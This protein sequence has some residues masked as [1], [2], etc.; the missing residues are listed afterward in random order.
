M[1]SD[2][3]FTIDICEWVHIGSGKEAY[4][5]TNTVNYIRQMLKSKGQF[6][7][8]DYMEETLSHLALQGWY[9]ID[10]AKD[11]NLLFTTDKL[12]NPPRAHL[13]CLQYCQEE[14]FFRPILQ[15]VNHLTV[16]HVCGVW[17]SIKWTS[18]RDSS[19]HFIMSNFGQLIHVQSE[20][21]W[22]HEVWGLVLKYDLK[23]LLDS[24]LIHLQNGP[25]YYHQPF[26]C[27]TSV[28]QLGLDCKIE[29][30]NANQGIMPESHNIWV[31]YSDS[32]LD[33]IFHGRDPSVPVL[34]F[35][36]T[37]LHQILQFQECL[38]AWKI[39]LTC[40]NLCKK[41][42]E[43]I[44]CA[45]AEEYASMIP[46]MYKDPHGWAECI[47]RFIRVLKQPHDMGTVHVRAS[48]GLVHL[49]W[50]NAAS[51]R[52]DSLWLVNYLADLNTYWTVF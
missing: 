10:S 29:Y 50:E 33:N 1:G 12:W 36:W 2:T 3:N 25:L 51:D 52:M 46:T 5:S 47:D 39:I 45:Q 8:P 34:C 21:V 38:P 27:P 23:A 4:Q 41:T 14:P 37:P 40:F 42:E 17:R 7:S 9:D 43:W 22:G 20:Q 32:D 26:R 35:S 31:H 28:E 16:T 18:L 19:E 13:L 48:V 30:T 24:M 11:F 6:T 49:V 15:Q 44:L